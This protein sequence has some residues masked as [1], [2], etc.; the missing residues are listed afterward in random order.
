M[1]GVLSLSVK[2]AYRFLEELI[3]K[4]K[5]LQR[6]EMRKTWGYLRH[7]L[8][9]VGLKQVLSSSKIPHEIVDKSS[10][11]YPNGHTYLMIE[12]PGAILTPA[13]VL[14]AKDIPPKAI[15]RSKGSI[16]NKQYNLFEN[17]E[18]L[19]QK[20]DKKNPPFLLL[21]YGGLN[22]TLSFVNLGIPSLDVV[23]WIDQVD[24]TNAPVL[25]TNPE[26]ISNEL[27]LTFTSR[28]EELIMRGVENAGEERTI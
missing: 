8:I 9:D 28:A 12:T 13:K 11:K 4:E 2:E 16:I 24:I 22:H 23:G 27:Q 1:I 6:E 3:Q 17:P 5:I 14:R 25:L 21:T 19:N 15:F 20:Y 7:G 26:E 18:D 10:S